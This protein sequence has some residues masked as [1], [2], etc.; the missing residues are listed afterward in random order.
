VTFPS[1]PE[2]EERK[3][4]V[5]IDTIYRDRRFQSQIDGGG[6]Q[7]GGVPQNPAGIR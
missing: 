3:E 1:A 4:I 5:L 2:G 6:P 7:V